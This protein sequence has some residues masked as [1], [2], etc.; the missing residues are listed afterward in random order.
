VLVKIWQEGKREKEIRRRRE[1]RDY[2][3]EKEA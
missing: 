2:E 3:W 1:G